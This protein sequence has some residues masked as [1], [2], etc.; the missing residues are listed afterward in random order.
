MLESAPLLTIQERFSGNSAFEAFRETYGRAVM[1]L[2]IDPLPDHRF[3]ID[4]NIIGFAGFGLAS[5]TLSPTN[6]RHTSA[7]I[8][9]DDVVLILPK[10]GFGSLAQMG[11]EVEVRDGSAA[12]ITNGLPGFFPGLSHASISNFRFSRAMLDVPSGHLEDALVRPIA[13]DHA[14]L[15]LLRNYSGVLDDPAALA[16]PEGRTVVSR[17]MHDLAGLLLGLTGDEAETSRRRGLRAAHMHALKDD[18]A[19]NLTHRELSLEIMAKRHG[20]SPRTIR[21]WFREMGTTFTDHVLEARLARAHRLLANPRFS[22]TTISSIAFD[23][24]FGDLSYFNHAFRRRYDATP[25]DVRAAARD[26]SAG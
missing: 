7:M 24:G 23:C 1:H 22:G 16:T 13:R 15:Q 8:Q 11:R 14:V 9:D 12:F 26:A 17:H 18:I 19:A 20:L 4:F 10:R 3:E 5:G 2:E 21:A 25:S 6:N